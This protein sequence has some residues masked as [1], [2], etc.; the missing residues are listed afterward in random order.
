[1]Q[2]GSWRKTQELQVESR[3][4]LFGANNVIIGFG[5]SSTLPKAQDKKGVGNGYKSCYVA[6]A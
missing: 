6:Y 5:A 4:I 1:M 3:Q 2:V